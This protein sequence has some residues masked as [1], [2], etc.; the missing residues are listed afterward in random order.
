LF[1]IYAVDLFCFENPENED[2]RV[3]KDECLENY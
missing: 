1:S 3:L 2:A